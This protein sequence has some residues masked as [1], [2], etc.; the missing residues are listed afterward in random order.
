MEAS[1]A[2]LIEA[3]TLLTEAN[4]KDSILA[5]AYNGLS[6]FASKHGDYAACAELAKKGYAYA[7]EV[8]NERIASVAAC[9]IAL[10][11]GRLGSYAQQIQWAQTA[12]NLNTRYRYPHSLVDAATQLMLGLAMT[13]DSDG[14]LKVVSQYDQPIRSSH[15]PSAIQSWILS[16]ADAHQILGRPKFAL[17][18]GTEATVG[19]YDTPL[20]LS[21]AGRFARWVA[22]VE[23]K[24]DA[25]NQG[26]ERIRHVLTAMQELDKIDQ[27]EIACAAR[28]LAEA[29]SNFGEQAGGSIPQLLAGFS[30]FVTDQLRRLGFS[31]VL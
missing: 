26:S 17:S 22:L 31:M 16:C 14:V 24:R 21:F 18:L 5:E 3:V 2:Q 30:P 11:L 10:S 12:I 27:L 1:H 19:Q 6:V 28:L 20:N 4:R 15:Q 29:G 13:N 23:L 9:N 8:D 7:T 25:K